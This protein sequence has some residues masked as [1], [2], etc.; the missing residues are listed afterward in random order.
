MNGSRWLVQLK[1]QNHHWVYDSLIMQTKSSPEPRM[2]RPFQN[3]QDLSQDQT[4]IV[5]LKYNV[6]HLFELWQFCSFV[7]DVDAI[8]KK[9]LISPN[10]HDALFP[11]GK[12]L[13]SS[14]PRLYY[15]FRR[16]P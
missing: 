9:R 15:F 10:M 7:E 3:P 2:A 12:M 11:N 4:G 8:F 16:G 5:S 6:D 1:Y 13:V 14:A